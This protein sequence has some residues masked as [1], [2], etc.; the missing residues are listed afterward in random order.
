M[1]RD[2]R[3][4]EAQLDSSATSKYHIIYHHQ[5]TTSH[6]TPG[7]SSFQSAQG[8]TVRLSL[9]LLL[10]LLNHKFVFVDFIARSL[11]GN[12]GIP[13]KQLVWGRKLHAMATVLL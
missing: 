7:D 5:P 12:V 1:S 10:M 13:C 6:D 9:L 11:F 4:I 3:S 8:A 2:Q